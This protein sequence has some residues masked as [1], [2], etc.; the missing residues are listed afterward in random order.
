MNFQSYRQFKQRQF[1]SARINAQRS[2]LSVLQERLS[3]GKRIN[4]PS[5]DPSG[6][7]AVI[8]SANNADRNRTI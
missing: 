4:R 3:T 8:K 1:Q 5:D 7:E 2:R 6:A